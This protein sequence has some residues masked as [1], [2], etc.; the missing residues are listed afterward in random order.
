MRG[1]GVCAEVYALGENSDLEKAV[2]CKKRSVALE[3]ECLETSFSLANFL[4][5]CGRDVE[6]LRIYVNLFN[7]R[8]DELKEAFEGDPQS[9]DLYWPLVLF[10]RYCYERT[11]EEERLFAKGAIEVLDELQAKRLARIRSQWVHRNSSMKDLF[12]IFDE[13]D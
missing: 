11:S 5:F 3:G 13:L 2:E 10:F 7:S 8:L 4:E 12:D 6:A 9:S 1:L